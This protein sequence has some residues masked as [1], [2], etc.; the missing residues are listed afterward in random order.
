M[1]GSWVFQLDFRRAVGPVEAAEADGQAREP[2]CKLL[3][4]FGSPLPASAVYAP[5]LPYLY[6]QEYVTILMQPA[7]SVARRNTS[8]I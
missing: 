8:C 1:E 5:C 3:G 6:G 7:D 4:S 2:D